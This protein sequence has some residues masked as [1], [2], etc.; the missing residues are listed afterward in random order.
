MAWVIVFAQKKQTLMKDLDRKSWI[1]LILSGI[2]TG[3]SWLFYYRA[4]QEGV[5]SIVVP[6]DKLS[7]VL[8]IVFARVFL[9]EKLSRRSFIGLCGIVAGPLVL[10]IK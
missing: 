2:T 4:L 7:I 10:L 1:F 9:K 6:I 8:T 5:A 3:S